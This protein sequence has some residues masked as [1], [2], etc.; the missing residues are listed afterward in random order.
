MAINPD[1]RPP[2]RRP[3]RIYSDTRRS[4]FG[5]FGNAALFWSA[6]MILAAGVVLLGLMYPIGNPPAPS[7]ANA[8]P[9][10]ATQPIKPPAPVPATRP[11]PTP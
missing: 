8:R 2:Y 7:D 9:S 1:P 6:L 4:R 5:F 3:P 11:A 10:E